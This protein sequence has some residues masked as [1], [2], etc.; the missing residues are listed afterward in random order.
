MSAPFAEVFLK[1]RRA[2]PFFSRHPWLYAGAIGRITRQPDVGEEVLVRSHEGAFVARGLYNPHSKIR[3]RLYGW[4]EGRPLDD[5]FWRERVSA[6][7]GCRQRLFGDGPQSRACRLIFSESDG[8]SGLTVDR[9]GDWLSLQWTSA[10]LALRQAPILNSLVELTGARGVWL[11]TERGIKELEGLELEDG[12]LAGEPPPLTLQIEENGLQFA[13]D[14]KEGQKTGFYFDQRDNR[15]AVANLVRGGR[16]LDVCTYTGGFA[17]SA[18][19]LGDASQVVAV[20]SSRSALDAAQQN[21]QANGV[22]D[23]IRWECDDA[24]DFVEAQ[25]QAGERYD[26][27]I[28]DPPK[29]ARTQGGLERALKAYLKL[30]RSALGVLNPGGLLCTCSCSGHVSREDFE[31]VLARAALESGRRLRILA[32]RGQALDHPVSPHCT[33]TAYLKCF[34]A[35]AE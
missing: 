5:A 20:D 32:E 26:V 15:I 13:V 28:L 24:F 21:A 23:R 10:A 9:Y 33:E 27:V 14:L 18:A 17:I 34:L 12:L 30:N 6:A 29:L 35:T 4:D 7:I 16:V 8:I 3:V 31:Q 25:V 2:L 19:K 11:R 22:A 1:P